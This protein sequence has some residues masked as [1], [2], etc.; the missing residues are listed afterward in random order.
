MNQAEFEARYN[1]DWEQLARWLE[2]EKPRRRAGGPVPEAAAGELPAEVLPH[3]Y[4]RVC[5]H[6]ALARERQYSTQLVGRLHR[7]VLLGHQQ[8]YQ[9]HMH[10][11]HRLLQFVIRD[12]P[13][14]VRRDAA[15]I[16]LSTLLFYGAAALM[17][18]TVWLAPEWIYTLMPP[19][20]VSQLERMY[21][22]GAE[23]IGRERGSDS[24]VMMFGFYIYNNI[25]IAF[26]TFASGLLFAVG[27]LFYLLFNGLFLG[28]AAGHLTR[29]EYTDTFYT[30]VIAHGAFELTAITFAGAAGL[31]LG[32]ALLRPGRHRRVTALRLAARRSIPVV[33]GLTLMLVVA[34]FIEAFWSSM[35][36]DP[37]IKYG[38]G[39]LCWLLVIA[40]LTL[41]GRDRAA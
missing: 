19:D 27:S 2:P 9:Q 40:Y 22:P 16:W 20:N 37:A 15:L 12:F 36:L 11:W 6:L 18:A 25:S 4:R 5:H 21:D 14:A 3:L 35:P 32:L 23:H 24:D 26:Q 17:F 28:A 39:A 38:V 31:R 8:L 34:A 29:L 41:A 7:L 30:F 10:G 33:Y 13:R 1:R